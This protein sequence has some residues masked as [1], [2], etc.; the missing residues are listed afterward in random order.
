[1]E[2]LFFFCKIASRSRL[3]PHAAAAQVTIF[4]S[5]TYFLCSTFI[6][7]VRWQFDTKRSFVFSYQKILFFPHI[8]LCS[9]NRNVFDDNHAQLNLGIKK[10]A[11]PFL[12]IRCTLIS[13]NASSCMSPVYTRLVSI[14]VGPK[15]NFYDILITPVNAAWRLH[16]NRLCSKEREE[17]P[18][19]S[20]QPRSLSQ[21]LHTEEREFIILSAAYKLNKGS[22]STWKRGILRQTLLY[23]FVFNLY[24]FLQIL[25]HGLLHIHILHFSMYYGWNDYIMCE[26][27]RHILINIWDIDFRYS[28]HSGWINSVRH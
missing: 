28:G 26:Y 1:M 25:Y 23:T 6:S 2:I 14:H 19:S 8:R 9:L 4:Q 18:D 3:S 24:C 13:C 5:R 12:W 20:V 10:I 17:S 27:S 22:N 11:L 7:V 21:A 15:S 16:S